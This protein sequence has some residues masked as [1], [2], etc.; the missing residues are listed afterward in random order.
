MKIFRTTAGPFAERPY[1]DLDEIERTCSSELREAGL[2]PNSPQP[3]RI[4]RFVE[5]RFGVTPEYEDLAPG[6][7]GW[8]K[9]GP[10]GV[11]A[12]VVARAL[13]EEQSRV[14]ERRI[15][16]TLAHEAGHGLLHA[17][18]FVLGAETLSLFG[19]DGD[20]EPQRILCREESGTK[21]AS[22][23][24]YSGQWWE[25]Q[26]NQA[27]GALLLPK[28]LVE[29]ALAEFLAPQGTLGER[30]LLEV[31]REDAARLLTETF[32][33][34]PVVARIRLANLYPQGRLDQLTL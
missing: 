15:S 34:N 22:P 33:V 6:V 29:V 21:T 17:H 3:I 4:D 13:S 23:P 25:F 31:H 30:I 5:R 14:A 18:L 20:V 32:D 11:E 2:Y 27:M 24:S 28:R 12:I 19:R 16:T 8:T 26:A 1:Y 7:L 10:K 9:F